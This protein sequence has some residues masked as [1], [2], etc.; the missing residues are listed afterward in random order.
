MGSFTLVD[1]EMV[2]AADTGNNFFVTIEDVGKPRAA[3]S[4]PS[5]YFR[6]SMRN[7]EGSLAIYGFANYF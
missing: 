4:E 6:R 1:H 3:V 7:L 5:A 2:S